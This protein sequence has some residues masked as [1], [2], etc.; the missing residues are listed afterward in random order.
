MPFIPFI[1]CV[2]NLSFVEKGSPIFVEHKLYDDELR[3]II[4]APHSGYIL[5]DSIYVSYGI[6][7]IPSTFSLCTNADEFK[8]YAIFDSFEKVTE[9]IASQVDETKDF[10]TGEITLIGK[11]TFYDC[12][13]CYPKYLFRL[14]FLNDKLILQILGHYRKPHYTYLEAIVFQRL[15]LLFDDQTY[16]TGT[17]TGDNSIEIYKEDF[18][19][20]CKKQ[21]KAIQTKNEK[22]IIKTYDS[23]QPLSM[24]CLANG[25]RKSLSA[26]GIKIKSKSETVF[27]QPESSPCYVYLMFDYNTGYYKIGISKSPKRREGTLQ[28]EKP[29]IEMLACKQYPDRKIALAIEK[30]LHNVYSDKHVRGEWFSLSEQDV[31]HLCATLV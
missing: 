20:L 7:E 28:S 30:A 23:A 21:I 29:T 26:N 9:T 16:V 25:I 2:H 19:L 12:D 11:K 18:E 1:P 6:A 4:V 22:G 10:V 13:G 5:I 31:A 17:S 3:R 24:I 15:T 14:A 8:G 27:S